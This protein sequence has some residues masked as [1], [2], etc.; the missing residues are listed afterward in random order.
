MHYFRTTSELLQSRFPFC[1]QTVPA[2]GFSVATCSTP[3]FC[4]GTSSWWDEILSDGIDW[5]ARLPAH[6]PSTASLRRS[7]PR[8]KGDKS[9]LA[10]PTGGC[11]NMQTL[12]KYF[13]PVYPV[14]TLDLK[15]CWMTKSRTESF[16]DTLEIHLVFHY[17]SS[18]F[19]QT[20]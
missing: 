6:D 19:C 13:V 17:F 7:L 8:D 10:M 20:V 11:I 14:G 16:W 9:T 3:L 1:G 15:S 2:G 5:L 12:E 18:H 4:H